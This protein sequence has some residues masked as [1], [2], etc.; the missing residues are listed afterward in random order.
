MSSDEA[1]RI[2]TNCSDES[3]E[4]PIAYFY[5]QMRANPSHR[6]MAE[7]VVDCFKRKGLVD[8]SYGLKDY[9]SG[10]LPTANEQAM[11]ACSTDP[12]GRLGE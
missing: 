3:G 6:D 10:D 2:E 9:Q 1:H 4:Y 11:T 7:A 8:P 12:D 5:V